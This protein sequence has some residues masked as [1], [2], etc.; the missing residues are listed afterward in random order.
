VGP[1][2]PS[3]DGAAVDEE[4]LTRARRMYQSRFAWIDGHA[5]TWAPLRDPQTLTL[6]IDA[7]AHLVASLNPTVVMSIEA[8][9]FLYGPAVASRAGIGFT[10]VRKAH[11]PVP[12]SLIEAQSPAD[13]RGNRHRLRLRR[14]DLRP[15]D[16]V[17]LVDDWIETGS[18]AITAMRMAEQAG[19][20]WAGCAVIVDQSA[21]ATGTAV[22]PVR[23]IVA[24]SAL[25]ATGVRRDCADD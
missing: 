13:Y 8:R 21:A 10:A 19:G 15:G 9:G 3:G 20:R 23:S 2:T 14:D 25:P 17:V 5:D 11:G 18:Q 16:R 22:G 6:I 4:L 12:G 24:A 7:L 1:D